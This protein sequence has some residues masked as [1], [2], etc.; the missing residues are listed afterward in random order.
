M[1]G[2]PLA[3]V[4]DCLLECLDHMDEHDKL[5]IVLYGDTAHVHLAPTWAS[6]KNKS[7]IR[8]AIHEIQSMGSTYMEAGLK[9]GY[10]AALESREDFEGIT[11]LVLF[12]DEQPNVGNT[13]A[14]GFIGLA[15]NGSAQ[16]VGLTT[17]GVGVQFQPTLAQE[18]SSVRGGNLFYFSDRE[19]MVDAFK[20]NFDLMF[21]EIAYNMTIRLTPADGLK[22]VGIYGLPGDLIKWE[23]DTMLMQI[24]TLFLSKN[25][26]AIYAALA[27]V[28]ADAAP[29]KGG[30]ARA[31][32]SYVLA[33][34]SGRTV[35]SSVSLKL[36]D[37]GS[38][39]LGL[40][41]G[42]YLVNEYASIQKALQNRE[43]QAYPAAFAEIQKVTALFETSD[44]ETLDEETELLAQLSRALAWHSGNREKFLPG[45]PEMLQA[46]AGT[47]II[48]KK[49][50]S[51][52][53]KGAVDWM[54]EED[55]S[56]ILRVW[57][58]GIVSIYDNMGMETISEFPLEFRDGKLVLSFNGE[59]KLC[60][61]KKNKLGKLVIDV[62]DSPLK[63][64][65]EPSKLV[66]SVILPGAGNE[67]DPVTGL[68]K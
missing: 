44:D 46:M 51:G 13:S 47:W 52:E 61:V 16:G 60:I 15:R 41:R 40:K 3:L 7:A 6:K 53:K 48:R 58:I 11:R 63:A 54:F 31:S 23:G 36:S 38:E 55:D 20:E 18:I 8:T 43:P 68:P 27:A 2:Q 14:E 22:I 4:K 1:N 21:C 24:E 49:D 59:E 62:Q 9:V 25:K 35:E 57:P 66:P 42:K 32:L 34:E 65:L 17:I 12:T 64:T 5:T 33:G 37:K 45:A 30:V 67:R 10:R 56:Y 26:G 50:I 19:M 28:D 29:T 39:G